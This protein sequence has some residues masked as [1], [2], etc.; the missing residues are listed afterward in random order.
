MSLSLGAF[1]DFPS[2]AI[3]CC[4]CTVLDTNPYGYSIGVKGG[5]KNYLQSLPPPATGFKKAFFVS[6][7]KKLE[8]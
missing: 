7:R 8:G 6:H 5:K 2:T 4:V 1:L 3:L